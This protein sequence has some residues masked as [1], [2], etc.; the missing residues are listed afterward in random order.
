MRNQETRS[1]DRAS[2]LGALALPY[3]SF[4]GLQSRVVTEAKRIS[5]AAIGRGRATVRRIALQAPGRRSRRTPVVAELTDSSSAAPRTDD[6]TIGASVDIAAVERERT[7]CAVIVRRGIDLGCGPYAAA[8]AFGTDLAAE[9]AIELVE[10]LASVADEAG[11][12]AEVCELAQ[13][14]DDGRNADERCAIEPVWALA[15]NNH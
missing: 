1:V 10:G 8:I 12:V 3:A 11:A 6:E 7:R 2:R 9:S 4:F 13:I 15:S 5:G 14:R